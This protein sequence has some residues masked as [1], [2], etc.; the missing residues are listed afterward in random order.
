MLF[1]TADLKWSLWSADRETWANHHAGKT[2]DAMENAFHGKG[3]AV[4]L[5]TAPRKEIRFGTVTVE[6][7]RATVEL[8]TGWDSTVDHVPE[9]VPEEYREEVSAAIERWFC[10][11]HGYMDEDMPT[12]AMATDEFEADSF[13]RLMERIDAL[14]E[15]L[16]QKESEASD[17]FDEFLAELMERF[18]TIQPEA[19]R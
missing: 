3:P 9:E 15:V 6:T 18:E 1:L 17:E 8:K 16:M 14:E 2:W 19:G 7:G 12:G 5:Y 11:R 4:R 13:D 10:E